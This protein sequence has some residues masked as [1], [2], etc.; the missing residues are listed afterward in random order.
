M[1]LDTLQK[2][3]NDSV[4]AGWSVGVACK[5]DP[6]SNDGKGR[7]LIMVMGSLMRS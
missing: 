3:L 4:A 2:W 5:D 7:F 1:D 6:I